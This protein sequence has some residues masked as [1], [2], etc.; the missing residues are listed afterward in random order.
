MRVILHD[1]VDSFVERAMPLLLKHEEMNTVMLGHLRRVLDFAVLATVETDT[2]VLAAATRMGPHN[3]LI[4]PEHPAAAEVLAEHLWQQKVPLPGVQAATDVAEAFAETWKR[5]SGCSVRP[6]VRLA[7]Y[8]LEQVNGLMTPPGEFR[9]ATLDDLPTLTPLTEQ[10]GLAIEEPVADPEGHTRTLIEQERLFV[11]TNE[12]NQPVS[13]AAWARPTPNGVCVNHVFTPEQ[14][15]GRGYATA[16]VAK[17][18]LYLLASGRRFVCL[19]A[20]LANPT[21]NGIY[22]RIGYRA[23]GEQLQLAFDPK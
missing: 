4:T 7:L 11:W 3:M 5:L 16:C 9:V 1:N 12:A 20:N 6:A 10:F 13:M 19:F 23:L 14:H 2:D 8:S 15:R 18:S 21:A 17:L 22:Q